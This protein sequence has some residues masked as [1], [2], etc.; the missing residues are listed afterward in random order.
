MSTRVAWE[1][2]CRNFRLRRS[3]RRVQLGPLNLDTEGT[4]Y[5]QIVSAESPRIVAGKPTRRHTG[6]GEKQSVH[7]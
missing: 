1:R 4:A 6:R 7:H 5:K 2:T 3:T